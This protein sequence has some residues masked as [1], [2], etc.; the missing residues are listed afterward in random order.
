MLRVAAFKFFNSGGSRSDLAFHCFDA[1]AATAAWQAAAAAA[2]AS[3]TH[4]FQPIASREILT[5]FFCEYKQVD[6]SFFLKICILQSLL[7]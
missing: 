2:A 1:A 6:K 3:E 5:N 7:Q 4:S